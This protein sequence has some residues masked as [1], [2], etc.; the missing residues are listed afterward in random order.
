M[1]NV[2][3]VLCMYCVCKQYIYV[4]CIRANIFERGNLTMPAEIIAIANQKGGVAKT[5]VT[6]NLGVA[7]ALREKKVLMV[8]LDSQASLTFCAGV[9]NPLEYDGRN[10]VSILEKNSNV[11]IRECIYP[12]G[13][14]DAIRSH[15]SL[16]PSII[17]LAQI[18]TI[19][20]SRTSRERILAKALEP[21]KWD[22]DYILLDCP[23]QLGLMTINALSAA[24]GVIIPCKTD[25]LSYRGLKQLEDTIS[26]IKELVNP[27]LE[28]YGVVATL[29]QS[30]VTHDKTILEKLYAEYRVLGVMK[31]AAVAKKGVF[32]GV[33]AVEYMPTHEIS[34]NVMKIADMI[35]KGMLRRGE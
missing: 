26:D 25:E 31:Q 8:D 2:I 9:K 6:H 28:I 12:V 5:T 30:R 32:D 35:I 16:L 24:D 29:H 7:L 3:Y 22:Y 18:E 20:Y 27:R 34:V 23:P 19:M 17:D 13:T 33:S 11:D 21:I 10:I 4:V 15:L 14:T 1:M